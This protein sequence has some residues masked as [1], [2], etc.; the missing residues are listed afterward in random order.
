M[1]SAR[2]GPFLLDRERGALVRGS[3]A[4]PIQDKPLEVLALLAER[5]GLLVTREEIR[6]RIW[7]KD[8]FV[9]F[10]DALNHAIRKI[11]EAIGAAGED[12]KLLE[13][14][15]RKGYRLTIPKLPAAS[16]SRSTVG[17][18]SEKQALAE[19]WELACAP[20][21]GES[22]RCRANPGWGRRRSSTA[23]CASTRIT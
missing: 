19:D 11:R 3:H 2:F 9:E 1:P 20:G 17:R 4:V 18:H 8:T 16:L 10:D 22:L 15:P 7:G 23:S 13:T 21:P 5:T 14:V 12:A 6:E